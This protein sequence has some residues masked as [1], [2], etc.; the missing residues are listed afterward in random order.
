MMKI[1]KRKDIQIYRGIAVLSVIFYHIDS[2]LFSSGFLG[3]DV[4]FV[5]S[6]FVISNL[7]YSDLSQNSFYLK[8]FYFQRFRRIFPSLVTFILFVQILI[9]FFLDHQF[10]YQTSRANLFSYFFV[11]NI[12]FSQILDYFNNAVSRNFVINLWSLSVEE[13]FYLLFPILA[14]FTKKYSTNKKIFVFLLLTVVS[15]VFYKESI[16]F[17]FSFLKK[18]FFT[19]SNF[20]FYSPFTRVWQ[21]SIGVISMFLN[22]KYLNKKIQISEASFLTIQIVLLYLL[23]N[24]FTFLNANIQLLLVMVAFCFLLIRELDLKTYKNLLIKFLIFTGNISYSLYLFHQPIFAS[25]KNYN[26]YANSI[27]EFSFQNWDY[28]NILFVL[29]IVY[30]VSFLNYFYIEKRYRTIKFLNLKEFKLI[31]FLFLVSLCLIFLSL[32]TNGYSFRGSKVATFDNSS[33]LEFVQGTNYISQETIQCIDRD[34]IQQSCRFNTQNSREIYIIGDSIM[35][36]IVS[37]FIENPTFKE[38]AIIEFTRG[39]CPLLIEKCNFTEGNLKYSEILEIKDSIIFIGGNYLQYFDSPTFNSDLISTL[40]LIAR[41]NKLYFF[42]SF[43]NPGINIRMYKLI[44][45][46]LPDIKL[47]T[48]KTQDP[49]I[50]ILEGANIQN[51]TLINSND[52]FCEEI[53]CKYYDNSKYYFIDHVHFS[54]FGAK[55]ISQ[56]VAN[57]YFK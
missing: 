47:N 16:F 1:K 12:Y 40:N 46:S 42:T 8:K 25:I 14:I 54:Y 17:S 26:Y 21:F 24:K 28:F 11:S 15:I 56:Y 6:G 22:Q 3:V 5:I 2:E 48:Y 38:Y 4:F 35:S 43:P 10:I 39:G 57:N 53:T 23:L 13:Q 51:L 18:I 33:N 19:H 41:Q 34:S 9:Y 31:L 27:F 30:L 49:I 7:I 52:I 44:N 29:L 50:N 55:I 20:I 45:N 37:G 32:S 36:S